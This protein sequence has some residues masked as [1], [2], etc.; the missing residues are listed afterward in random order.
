MMVDFCWMLQRDV[1]QKKIYSRQS[2][3]RSFLTKR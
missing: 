3:K 2:I 1:P